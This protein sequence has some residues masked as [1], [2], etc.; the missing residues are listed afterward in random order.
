MKTKRKRWGCEEEDAWKMRGEWME[1]SN[2][3]FYFNF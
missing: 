2:L 1:D 3:P